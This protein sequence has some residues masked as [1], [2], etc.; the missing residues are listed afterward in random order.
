MTGPQPPYGVPPQ[1]PQQNRLP[2]Q[3]CPLP[4]PGWYRHPYTGQ[5]MYWTGTQWSATQPT[6]SAPRTGAPGKGNARK[7]VAIDPRKRRNRILAIVAAVVAVCIIAAS[8]V[9]WFMHKRAVDREHGIY[10]GYT[11]P[12]ALQNGGF[13]LQEPMMGL[14]WYHEFDFPYTCKDGDKGHEEVAKVYTDP[15]LTNEFPTHTFCGLNTPNT[16]AVSAYTGV[17]VG[18]NKKIYPFNKDY[19]EKEHAKNFSYSAPLSQRRAGSRWFGFNGYYL[20]R[21]VGDDGKK[22]KKPQVTYFTVKDDA[23]E[24]PV[25]KNLRASIDDNGYVTVRWDPVEGVDKYQVFVQKK[26]KGASSA[27]QAISLIDN[28]DETSINSKSLEQSTLMFDDNDSQNGLF[29]DLVMGDT[30]D[31]IEGARM[32][33]Q[34]AS[35]G[36]VEADEVKTYYPG[37]DTVRNMS[38]LV[39]ATDGNGGYSPYAMLR[40]ND[41]LS[42]IP[43]RVSVNTGNLRGKRPEDGIE[44]L[45]YE[46]VG[47]VNMADGTIRKTRRVFDFDKATTST[48]ISIQFDRENGGY[49]NRKETL[50]WEVPCTIKGTAMQDKV[51]IP[52]TDYPTI[53]ALK[54]GFD[55]ADSQLDKENPGTGLLPVVDDSD[56]DWEQLAKDMAVET[57]TTMPDLSSVGIKVK[58]TDELVKYLG[59]N[60]LAGNRRIN[61][62][63]YVGAQ[64]AD[65]SGTLQRAFQEAVAQNPLTFCAYTCSMTVRP[66]GDGNEPVVEVFAGM[67]LQ[68]KEDYLKE[69]DKVLGVVNA[70][71]KEA[72]T[73]PKDQVAYFHNKIID[74]F[75]YDH[76]VFKDG[77][78]NRLAET[79][80][81]ASALALEVAGTDDAYIVC[82]GYAQVMQALLN[83]S[84]IDSWYVTG[85]VID[86]TIPADNSGHAWNVVNTGEGW[87]AVDVTWDDSEDGP[88]QTEFLMVPFDQGRMASRTYDTDS[89]PANV[90]SGIVPKRMVRAD[91]GSSF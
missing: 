11:Y 65:Q 42:Q 16:A 14:E 35:M 72:G 46:A 59:A 73:N 75:R 9:G 74:S 31:D 86:P 15:A 67:K 57:A 21:Y 40:V 28:T 10:G 49:K 78:S 85:N 45:K 26:E 60:L 44:L 80:Y 29:G 37:P 68:K 48:R 79:E 25:P 4:Q 24:L 2:N 3:Q 53:D 12:S 54:K 52:A 1:Q 51:S 17:A 82:S 64:D 87:T 32:D 50:I 62:A 55:E 83:Q 56:V 19:D 84:G 7:A 90:I 18:E 34:Y 77:K 89:L 27:T 43:I 71:V 30:A 33:L 76:A 5:T 23:D 41:L 69:R 70:W 61:V 81:T 6:P 13:D 39:R 20:V 66:D 58:G 8:G 47:Y 63:H 22:L 36:D 38:F 88:A 91:D